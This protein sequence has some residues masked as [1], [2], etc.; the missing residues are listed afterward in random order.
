MS[1]HELLEFYNVSKEEKDEE[2]PRNV[3]VLEIEG[4]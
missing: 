4:E 1:V 2:H 3:Q